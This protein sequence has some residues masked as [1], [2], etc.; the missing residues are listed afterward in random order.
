MSSNYTA[1]NAERPK[2]VPRVSL[3][4]STAMNTTIQ[5]TPMA[6]VAGQS[7]AVHIIYITLSQELQDIQL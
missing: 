1:V 2:C 3:L 6:P 7:V 4:L 5:L